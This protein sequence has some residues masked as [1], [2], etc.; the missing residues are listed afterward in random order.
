MHK[1]KAGQ[2]I[3][4][5]V[6]WV[7]VI[8]SIIPFL[9]MIS[10]SFS[11]AMYELPY[12]PRILPDSINFANY[13]TVIKDNNFIRYFLNSTVLATTVTFCVLLI[14]AMSA[15]GFARFDFPFKNVIFNIYLITMMVPGVLNLIAQYS[16]INSLHL[17]NHYSGILLLM[18]GSGIAGNTFF[19]RGFFEDIPRELEESIIIDGGG[20]WV[21]FRRLIIPLSKPALG[22]LGIGIFSGTWSDFFTVL[23]FIKD[24]DMWT[25]PVALQ[26]FRGQHATEW[27]LVF[28]GSVILFIPE[29]IMFIIVQKN[30]VQSSTVDGAIKG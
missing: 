2:I 22:T 8:L 13:I 3:I 7:F 24:P 12:P 6:L 18:V 25:L 27:G 5:V 9:S 23:T 14:S 17:V 26:L 16:I 15:Y 1:N 28:A 4:H 11:T 19:L 10:T 21:I 29:L 30:L 20:R